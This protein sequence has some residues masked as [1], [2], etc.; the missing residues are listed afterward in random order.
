MSFK[1]KK[2]NIESKWKEAIISKL[3]C[4]DSDSIVVPGGKTPLFLYKEYFSKKLSNILIPSDDRLTEDITKSNYNFI[5]SYSKTRVIKLC[6]FPVSDYK[7]VNLNKIS[8]SILSCQPPNIG[9]LGLGD[10]GHFASIFPNSITI[11]EDSNGVVRIIY[12]ENSDQK[13]RV[14]LTENFIKSI[15]ELLFIVK[16]QSKFK[17]INKIKENLSSI[18]HLPIGKLIQ[19]YD[20]K[21]N[22]MYC[23]ND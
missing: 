17:I 5:K 16:G 23:V 3:N 18:K 4:V 11:K 22:I 7:D 1:I 2:F 13:Y 19:S 14:T 9:L 8:D 20:G 10:D 15:Q 21:L 12:S 6:E